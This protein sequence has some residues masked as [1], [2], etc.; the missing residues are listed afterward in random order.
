MGLKDRIE[1]K[2][3]VD[4]DDI[5]DEEFDRANKVI[6]VLQ[7]GSVQLERDYRE[8]DTENQILA[9]LI[10]KRY[11]FEADRVDEPST[12]YD[13]FYDSIQA[14]DSTIRH[15]M[16]DL[17]DENIVEKDEN[18]KWSLVVDSIDIALDRLLKESD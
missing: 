16:N 18:D 14:D 2:M 3:V 5:L 6:R 4:S 17:E 12:R 10:G 11:A 13:Y 7:D 9:Y 8:M 1:E 15:K